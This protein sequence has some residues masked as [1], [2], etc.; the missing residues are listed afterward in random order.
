VARAVGRH[1]QDEGLVKV[2]KVP[3]P[4][5]LPPVGLITIPARLRTPA[6]DQLIR[7]LR[8]VAPART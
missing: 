4:I 6:C 8:E 3:V 7:C 1:L 5:E 2:L